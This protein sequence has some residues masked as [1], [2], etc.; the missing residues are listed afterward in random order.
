MDRHSK[1]VIAGVDYRIRETKGKYDITLRAE[2]QEEVLDYCAGLALDDERQYRFTVSRRTACGWTRFAVHTFLQFENGR[3]DSR[4]NRV[5]PT[6]A[7][8]KTGHVS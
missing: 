5:P 6:G 4:G 2:T 3:K 7:I 1:E 8:A